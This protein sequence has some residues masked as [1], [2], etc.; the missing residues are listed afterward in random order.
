MVGNTHI[1]QKP[2]RRA[3]PEPDEPFVDP[4]R[5]ITENWKR[6]LETTD[7]RSVTALTNAT[8][9]CVGVRVSVE[10]TGK[11][12]TSDDSGTLVTNEK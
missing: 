10:P 1:L 6:Y 2:Y 4:K 5:R 8:R 3:R 11:T 9:A 7:K 12:L